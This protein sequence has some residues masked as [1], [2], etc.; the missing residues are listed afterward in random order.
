MGVTVVTRS[1]RAV[2]PPLAYRGPVSASG[3]PVHLRGRSLGLVWLGGSLGTAARYGVSERLPQLHDV[4][5]GTVAV[6]V[7]GAFVLGLLLERLLRSGPDTGGRR[8]LRLLAGTGF[9][10][11][12]T[13]Y[14]ALATDTVALV[15]D[16]HLGRAAAYALGTLLLGGLASLL[17]VWCG[18]R[19]RQGE[20]S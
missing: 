12:F 9:L 11:G 2:Q 6:N 14:S 13:T 8:N 15:G 5:I 17:G 3:L 20:P 7:A 10:G 4:P 18:G 16:D 1:G 19:G